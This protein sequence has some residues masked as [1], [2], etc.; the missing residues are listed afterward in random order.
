MTSGDSSS[1]E[2]NVVAYD[3]GTSDDKKFDSSKA[4]RFNGAPEEFCWCK[5]KMYSYIMGLDEELWDVLEDGV[6]DL[7][8][9]EEGAAID[10]KKHIA[11]QKKLYKKHH[12]I[13]GILVATLLRIEYCRRVINLLLKLPCLFISQK[14][15]LVKKMTKIP[16]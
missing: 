12:K 5:T 9:D 11:G 4:P 7:A 13:R 2:N 16:F 3:Y 6:A 14:Y 1:S 10:R 8:L 15:P